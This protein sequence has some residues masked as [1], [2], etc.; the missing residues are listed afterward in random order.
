LINASGL[1]PRIF[2]I[3]LKMFALESEIFLFNE[4]K[5]RYVLSPRMKRAV[6]LFSMTRI[7]LALLGCGLVLVATSLSTLCLQAYRECDY[8]RVK[9]QRLDEQILELRG[10][11]AA[12]E[13]YLTLLLND[14][15]F[16]ERVVRTHLG[17]TRPGEVIFRFKN[18][19][20]E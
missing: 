14:I 1:A 12:R 13:Q 2:T 15:G 3:R 11:I 20:P 4:L 9:E 5:N 19:R 8:M 10:D 6:V 7:I 16:L 17:Y 18:P